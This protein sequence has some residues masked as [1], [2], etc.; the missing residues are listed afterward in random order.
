MYHLLFSDSV[1]DSFTM[2]QGKNPNLQNWEINSFFTQKDG[3]L[4]CLLCKS[5]LQMQKQR[6][7]GNTVRHYEKHH[8]QHSE[9]FKGETRIKLF[10]LLK[11]KLFNI[12]NSGD[13]QAFVELMFLTKPSEPSRNS[14]SPDS[15]SACGPTSLE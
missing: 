12:G 10:Q 15:C 4:N 14:S 3:K 13:K 7:Y 1:I 2:D 8:P 11:R 6:G 9:Q 5:V